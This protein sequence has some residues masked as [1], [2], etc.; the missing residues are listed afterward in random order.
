MLRPAYLRQQA[1]ICLRLSEGCTNRAT[2]DE[3]RLMAAEFYSQAIAV[4]NGWRDALQLPL[5]ED[6]T[7]FGW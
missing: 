6:M 5:S 7:K 4:E 3:L 2:A 1:E